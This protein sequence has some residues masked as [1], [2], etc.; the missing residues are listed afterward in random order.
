MWTQ[1]LDKQTW[2]AAAQAHNFHR[3]AMGSIGSAVPFGWHIF[4]TPG[5]VVSAAMEQCLAES[6]AFNQM[7]ENYINTRDE[8]AKNYHNQ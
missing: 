2:Q 8:A 4:T 1:S 7:I 6:A 3:N 5:S